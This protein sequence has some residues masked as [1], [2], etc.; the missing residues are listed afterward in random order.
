M[1]PADHIADIEVLWNYN[2]MRQEVR[3]CDVAIVLGSHDI[4]V[5]GVAAGL[6]RQGLFPMAVFS[7]GKTPAT[8]G[9]FPRGEAVH[10]RE[11]AVARGMPEEATLLETEAFNTGE[12]ITFS[13]Q[14]LEEA[15]HEPDS[16]LLVTKPYMERRAYATCRKKWPQA[17]P[18]CASARVPL[19][20]YLESCAD[21]LHTVNMIV[22][23]TR[24]VIEYP[25]RGYAIPQHVP[26]HVHAALG[27]LVRAGYTRHLPRDR[28][29][30]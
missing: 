5:A 12:N 27:R 19:A 24:R 30:A 11:H 17:A 25:Q 2:Q 3:R 9:L 4:G 10:F 1:L 16:V 29:G 6:Y 20:R 28:A 18:V 14:V 23:D 22:G 13:R 15:G 26:D 8:A 21:P 7:G